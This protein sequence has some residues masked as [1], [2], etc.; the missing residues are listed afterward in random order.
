[1]PPPE[2]RPAMILDLNYK[3]DSMGREYAQSFGANY[4]SGLVMFLAQAQGQRAF[5]SQCEEQA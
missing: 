4:T 3:E 5:W 1:M 2:W